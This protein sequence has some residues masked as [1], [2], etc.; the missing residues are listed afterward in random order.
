M[1]RHYYRNYDLN[2]VL[3]IMETKMNFQQRTNSDID[4]FGVKE[5]FMRL[6]YCFPIAHE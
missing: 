6:R 4:F 3:I 5:L 1:K 2:G